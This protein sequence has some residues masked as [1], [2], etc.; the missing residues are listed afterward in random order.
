M[1]KITIL[2]ILMVIP[3]GY[4]ATGFSLPTA[5][6]KEVKVSEIKEDKK[7]EKTDGESEK[8]ETKTNA[9]KS[10]STEKPFVPSE[11]IG[12]DQEVD[13]PYDI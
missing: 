9:K 12:A 8:T 4:Q 13:F 2:I 6:A 11:K 1:I 5:L 10:T 3:L 7:L